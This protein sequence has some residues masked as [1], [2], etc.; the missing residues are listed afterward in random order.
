M[1][2]FTIKKVATLAATVAVA[3]FL[4]AQEFEVD[5][6]TYKIVDENTKMVEITNGT[7]ASGEIGIPPRVSNN[8]E[9]YTVIAIA[10]QAF[11]GNKN[12]TGVIIPE[13]VDTIGV[14]AFEG[15]DALSDVEISEGVT[16]IK[17]RAF[18]SCASLKR[19]RIPSTAINLESNIFVDCRELLAI[20]VDPANPN[21]SSEDGILF[22][23]S[24]TILHRYPTRKNV[25]GSYTIPNTVKTIDVGAFEA[26]L[27]TQ[28]TIPNSVETIEEAAFINC[29]RLTSIDIP[30]SVKSI[31]TIAFF[32]CLNLK[33]IKISESVSSIGTQAFHM[34]SSLQ[35]IEVDSNSQY[36]TSIDGALLSKDGKN[37]I[38]IPT[39]K[40]GSYTVPNGVETIDSYAYTYGLGITNLI[41]PGT[42]KKINRYAFAGATGIKTI[43]SNAVEP[44]A[45][46]R[47]LTIFQGLNQGNVI[48]KVPVGSAEKYKA[49][50]VWKDFIIQEDAS[51]STN[52]VNS[53][54]QGTKVYPNPTTGIFFV[55]T[56]TAT[57]AQ[58]ISV[59][60]QVVKSTKLSKGKNE[61]NISNLSAGLYLVKVGDK[62]FKVLKK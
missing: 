23:K 59:S 45:L 37:L 5:N 11:R 28:I 6:I 9:D 7:N 12:I 48:L 22:N 54:E 52:D 40:T 3:S 62:T 56:T 42:L 60:G 8:G 29:G 1:Y 20:T 19:V 47:I 10:D 61:I 4:Q 13:T 49:A 2:T 50:N 21:Y 55:E 15:C 57:E 14:Y 30:N 36:F 33:N 35:S 51:L 32:S 58:I 26:A 17:R 34:M 46:E 53:V 18:E 38:K 41:L 24:K 31:G 25:G 39:A 27:F 44:P 43:S 16:T